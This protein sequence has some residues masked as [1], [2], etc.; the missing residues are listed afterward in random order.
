MPI[1]VAVG[2][3][4]QI[5]VRR[6]LDRSRVTRLAISNSEP[7]GG[8]N[9]TLN[10]VRLLPEP[11]WA[12]NF[13]RLLKIDLQ[14]RAGPVFTS[15][16]GFY[17]DTTYL[18]RRGYGISANAQVAQNEDREHPDALLEDWISFYHG[19][20]AFDLPPGEYGCYFTLEDAGYW[21]YYPNWR[22]REVN[23]SGGQVISETTS[24]EQWWQKYYAHED[25]EDFPG[26]SSWERYIR[27]RYLD[28]AKFLTARVTS[29][30]DPTSPSSSQLQIGFNCS[31]MFAC[32]MSSLLIWP[33]A[34]NATA[35]RFLSELHARQKLQY[36]RDYKQLM[37]PP[38]GT[39]PGAAAKPPPSSR[40]AAS[41]ASA[42][43]DRL[44]F[45]SPDINEPIAANANPLGPSELVGPNRP[46]NMTLLGAGM[47]APAYIC[48]VDTASAA[49]DSA[50]QLTAVSGSGIGRSAF[51][52]S[53]IRYKQ[54]RL[55]PDGGIWSNQPRLLL[56]TATAL[57]LSI[58]SNHTRCLWI[59]LRSAATALEKATNYSG[60]ISL[61]FGVH[62]SVA[63]GISVVE[64]PAVLPP[65]T[66]L[67]IGYMGALP[68]YPEAVWPEVRLKQLNEMAP[69]LKLMQNYGFT[70][71]TGGA[72]G[73]N[74]ENETLADFGF[75]TIARYFPDSPINS[76]MGSDIVGL[77]VRQPVPTGTASYPAEV[78]AAL[79]SIASHARTAQWRPF[80]Q[81]VGDEPQGQ[82]VDDSIAVAAA[83]AAAGPQLPRP[84]WVSTSIFTSAT[85]TT[86]DYT[87]RILA[88]NCSVS[89][90]ALNEHSA[91]A[92][93]MLQA[94]GH[95]WMLYNG[96]SRFRAGFYLAMASHGHGALGIYEFALSSVGAD[97][98]YALDAR[99][100]D[101]A[102][103][104]T[105][106]TGGLVTVIDSVR[107]FREGITDLRC[108]LLL[109]KLLQSG[110]GPASAKAAGAKVLSEID[111]I[112]LGSEFP[113]WNG[114]QVA[115]VRRDVDTAIADLLISTEQ[116][117]PIVLVG[118]Q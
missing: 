93:A 53:V 4:S 61:T 87:A 98:Y 39:A 26:E 42:A 38:R 44:I 33:M 35:T 83:F 101:I 74:P 30:A 55:T 48:F 95:Q 109:R 45:F 17:P 70:A 85:N 82:A 31:G 19:S 37:P 99:E 29:P 23:V 110:A 80:F 18:Q 106:S 78:V 113:E 77:N 24:V 103:A 2:E 52:A 63:L 81:T 64:L 50:M 16:S 57:P 60:V 69:V 89:L 58:S 51:S 71:A 118:K 102:A 27:P 79:K 97:P 8:P 49:D 11:P 62:G 15:F 112:P 104:Y 32:T 12:N 114:T 65:A 100:D 21:E 76:Y 36:D 111:A 59:E 72:G 34:M 116:I 108:V 84:A 67:W 28:K 25:D 66:P 105:T 115:R 56:P 75:Q 92:V 40:P 86:S 10:W 96:G 1:N 73:P 9:I 68:L 7:T 3:K 41:G 6:K 14:P 94:N 88:K 22:W 13:N 47:I 117:V 91:S 46:I 90:I 5:Q 107:V 54:R 20:I 43:A